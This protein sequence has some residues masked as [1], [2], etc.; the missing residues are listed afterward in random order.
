[1]TSGQQVGRIHHDFF[2]GFAV[3]VTDIAADPVG[4]QEK[5]GDDRRR[6]YKENTGADIGA[7]R[8]SE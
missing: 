2:E 3:A 5:T 1:M 7:A 4:Q 8:I 6:E